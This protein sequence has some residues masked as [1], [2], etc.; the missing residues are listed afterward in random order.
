MI[1]ADGE[2]GD[3]VLSILF[4][5]SVNPSDDHRSPE[6]G[7]ATVSALKILGGLGGSNNRAH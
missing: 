1:D 2:N 3:F 5:L 7:S 6:H 4:V